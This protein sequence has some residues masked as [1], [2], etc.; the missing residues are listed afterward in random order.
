LG[1]E[2][3][4][5]PF[6][7]FIFPPNFP[8]KNLGLKNFWLEGKNPSISPK[9]GALLFILFGPLDPHFFK[10]FH[11]FS[12]TQFP[13]PI[14]APLRNFWVRNCWGNLGVNPKRQ[15]TPWPKRNRAQKEGLLKSG[16]QKGGPRVL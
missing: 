3:G 12:I 5:R 4:T 8:Q 11:T 9:G 16:A 2:K 7:Q 13:S 15:G 6:S 10:V 14:W 1:L